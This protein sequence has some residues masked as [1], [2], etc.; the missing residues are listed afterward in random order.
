[1]IT[2]ING[3]PCELI[4]DFAQLRGGDLI[5]LLGCDWCGKAP[6]R[7]LLMRQVVGPVMMPVGPQAHAI[8][9]MPG[10]PMVPEPHKVQNG[11]HTLMTPPSVAARLVWRV[12]HPPMQ[13]EEPTTVEGNDDALRQPSAEQV[14]ARSTPADR[15]KVG[16]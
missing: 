4:T 8:A 14:H 12:I 7:A 9:I 5:Y 15:E 16:R 10:F 13:E 3:E 1:M 2:N 11:Q 6:H